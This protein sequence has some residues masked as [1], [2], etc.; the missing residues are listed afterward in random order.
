MLASQL[1]LSR[2]EALLP[3]KNFVVSTPVGMSAALLAP[4]Q[5]RFLNSAE[6][7]MIPSAAQ[8]AA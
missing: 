2:A 7:Q 4:N 8:V 6:T 1:R 3:G 5:M